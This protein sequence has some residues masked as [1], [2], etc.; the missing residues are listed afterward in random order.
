MLT[1]TAPFDRVE[2][3]RTPFFAKAPDRLLGQPVAVKVQVAA[4][5]SS[6]HQT[7][8]LF[9]GFVTGLSTGQ[10][11]DQAGSVQVIV[12]SIDY[13]LTDGLQRRTF[14]QQTLR[15]IF[16]TVLQPYDV[17]HQLLPQ[18]AAPLPYVVQYQE[19]NFDYL[20]RLA[21]TCGEWFYSDG[22]TLRLGPPPAGAEIDFAADGIHNRF[23]FGLSLRPTR[24]T[25]YGYDYRQH[26]HTTADTASHP[27]AGLQ[28]NQYGRLALEQSDKLF[29]HPAHALAETPDPT[30]ALLTAE[31]QRLKGH[32]AA[33]LVT[34]QGQSENPALTLGAVVNINGKGMG[35]EHAETD[36]FGTYR[37]TA[38]T[39]F[40]DGRSNYRNTFTAIPH[41]LD[42]PPVSPH[43]QGP[44][45]TAEPAEVID[46]R[47]PENLGRIRVRYPWPVARPQDGET[48]WLRVLTPYSGAGKGQLFTPEVGSQVLVGYA[49]GLA[50]QPYVQGN[51]F[52]GRNEAGAK[53]THNGS[54][55]KGIQTKGGN[56]LTFFDK[57]GEEK[58]LVTNGKYKETALEITFK[59]DGRI[60]LKTKG[61]ISLAAGK[62]VSIQAGENVSI[63]AGK[64]ISLKAEE[65]ASE[66]SQ[67]TAIKASAKVTVMGTS[68]VDVKGKMK[69]SA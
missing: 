65:L 31:A 30:A 10:D 36:S 38:L 18:H 64:K 56:K 44:A 19:S 26:R 17:P 23:S 13:L 27:V 55:V 22:Q 4:G 52:H 51:L 37:L 1:I 68:G 49:H 59:G 47:D 43:H 53:Y 12:H 24:A 2:S 58:I 35:S 34:V 57:K 16:A 69:Q 25:L 8:L 46:A 41:L 3:I 54:E 60:E 28:R 32:L 29:P 48:D 20:S 21:A 40:V 7:P 33:G 66:T 9:K 63:R 5:F 39:H 15:Q 6:V 11:S 50:E 67:A 42:L 45:G 62:N 14:R 61:D